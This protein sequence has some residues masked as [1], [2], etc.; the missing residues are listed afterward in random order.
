[1][2]RL[3]LL[4]VITCASAATFA[5]KIHFSDTSNYWKVISFDPDHAISSDMWHFTG[6]VLNGS[7]VREDTV[8][9]KVY[10]ISTHAPDYDT[11]EHLLYDYNLQLGDTIK[12]H[13]ARH[14]V[15]AL[16]SIQINGIWH[17][18]WDFQGVWGDT[19][20][21]TGNMLAGYKVLEGVG[22]LSTPMFPDFPFGF[23]VYGEVVCFENKGNKPTFSSNPIYYFDNTAS[24]TKSFGLGVGNVAAANAQP[25]L[26]PNPVTE[27]TLLYLPANFEGT[28]SIVSVAGRV[29][30]KQQITGQTS[31]TIA[32]KI[33]AP[34]MYFYHIT[35]SKTG[36]T[37]NGKFVK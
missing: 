21:S 7:V 29:V 10:A 2:K 34:G 30:Y 3:I 24:C 17:K 19:A 12:T 20:A 25:V 22:C 13:Y 11:N 26:F 27:A 33:T 1:M 16:D 32:E 23:E 9:H 15:S 4:L 5:Q 18:V 28:V 35:D 37:T 8:T 36:S 14:I 31:I 6:N